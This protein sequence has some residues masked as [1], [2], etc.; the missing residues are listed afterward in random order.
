MRPILI[1]A[2]QNGFE[3]KKALIQHLETRGIPYEDAGVFEP[4][5]INYPDIAIKVAREVQ[6]GKYTRAILICGTGIGMAITANKVRGVRAA[7]IHDAYSAERAQ[8]SNNAQ[9]ACFGAQIIAPLA[10]TRMLDIWL[11]NEYVPGGR[12]QPK[13]DIIDALDREG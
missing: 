3:L 1:G 4:E 7:V 8:A 2:D 5:P 6:T 13:L 11:A 9:I 10:A 12:S